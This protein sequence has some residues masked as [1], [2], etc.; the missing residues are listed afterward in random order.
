V[1]NIGLNKPSGQMYKWAWTWSPLGG[2]CPHHCSYCYVTSDIAPRLKNFGNDKYYGKPRLIESELHCS[3]KKPDDGKVI[4]V[5]SCGDLFARDIPSQWIRKVI[6]HC[7]EYPENT[8]LFQSKNPLRFGEFCFPKNSILGTTMESNKIYNISQ[9][10]CVVSRYIAMK[11]Y[12]DRKMISLEPLMDFDLD[13]LVRWIREIK[14]EFV[15]IGADSKHHNLPE[16]DFIKI[17]ELLKELEK[18][19]EVRIKINLNYLVSKKSG[20]VSCGGVT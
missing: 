1:K 10:P 20:S 13:V 14:P 3:L 15:S 12:K 18:F 8:Y 7:E 11:H 5:E 4:F 19:T 2:E 9:A 16:P 17:K 6:K